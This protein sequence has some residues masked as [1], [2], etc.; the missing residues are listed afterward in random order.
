MAAATDHVMDLIFGRRRSQI[1]YAGTRLGVSDHL[2]CDRF[3]E[4][5]TVAPAV[6]ADPALLYR[7]LRALAMLGLLAEDAPASSPIYAVR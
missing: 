3:T 7:L 4:A 6:N 2:L 5:G 1:L